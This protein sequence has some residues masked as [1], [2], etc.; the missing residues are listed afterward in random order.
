M[1]GIYEV[2]DFFFQRQAGYGSMRKFGE[3]AKPKGQ[4]FIT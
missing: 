1:I 3:I 4:D 2:F